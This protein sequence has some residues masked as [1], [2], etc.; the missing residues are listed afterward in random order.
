MT[1]SDWLGRLCRSLSVSMIGGLVGGGW[2][3]LGGKLPRAIFIPGSVALMVI[4]CIWLGRL[5][6]RL[7][8]EE[9]KRNKLLEELV[10]HFANRDSAYEYRLVWTSKRRAPGGPLELR[11]HRE[12]GVIEWRCNGRDW[13]TEDMPDEIASSLLEG[14]TAKP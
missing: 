4:G 2:A 13:S 5:G 12:T 6:A 7:G 1:H 10:E 3:G 14:W 8:R 11:R 9:R